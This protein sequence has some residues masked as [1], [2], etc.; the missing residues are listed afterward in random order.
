MRPLEVISSDPLLESDLQSYLRLL[1]AESDPVL[2]VS[3]DGDFTAPLGTS[4]QVA[5]YH[6][7]GFFP[8]FPVVLCLVAGC[9]G[10]V[11]PFHCVPLRGITLCSLHGRS[12]RILPT[13]SLNRPT[14][15]LL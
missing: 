11:S 8:L 6:H 12:S 15:A 4:F 7:H 5:D 10:H 14:P 3:C 13:S 2:K 1:R 9:V